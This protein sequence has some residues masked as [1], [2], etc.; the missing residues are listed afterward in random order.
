MYRTIPALTFALFETA[1]GPC[2][3]AW[4]PAG[5]VGVQLP[6]ADASQTLL[7]MQQRFSGAAHAQPPEAVQQAIDGIAAMLR[8]EAHDLKALVLD[9]SGVP[10]FHQRVYA[11]TRDISPGKTLTYGEVAA[12]L[13]E[14]GASRAVGQALGRNPFAPVVPC[15]RVLAAGD[16]PGGFSASGGVRTKLRLLLIEGAM[17]GTPGLFD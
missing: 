5:I 2:A 4:G 11:V 7:R 15:H 14:P 6:E 10:T 3:I 17:R 8:G 9:M 16:K 12:R 1:I 13:G